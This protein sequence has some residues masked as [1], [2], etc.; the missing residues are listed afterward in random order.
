MDSRR[1]G[2]SPRPGVERPR[3]RPPQVSLACNAQPPACQ[4]VAK[5]VLRFAN[6]APT[7]ACDIDTVLCRVVRLQF[8]LQ[9]LSHG[10]TSVCA[11]KAAAMKLS[12]VTEMESMPQSF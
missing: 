4:P 9:T 3:L 6:S 2:R 8:G 11:S 12:G 10:L 7:L 5:R 1:R